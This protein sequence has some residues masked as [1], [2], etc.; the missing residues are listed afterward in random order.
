MDLLLIED[1][2]TLLCIVCLKYL[3][4]V[5]DEIDFHQLCDFLFI[6]NDEYIDLRHSY[7]FP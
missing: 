5:T 6:V 4:A 7:S 1:F 2:Q 3:I